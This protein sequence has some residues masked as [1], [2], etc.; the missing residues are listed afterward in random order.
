MRVP[1]EA[2]ITAGLDKWRPPYVVKGQ[3]SATETSA[4]TK[5]IFKFNAV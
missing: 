3:L 5:L 4:L 2:A 1:Q